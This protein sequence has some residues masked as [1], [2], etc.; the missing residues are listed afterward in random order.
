MRDERTISVGTSA[1]ERGQ[2]TQDFVVGIG[3]F[4]LAIAFVFS[5]LPSLITPFDSPAGGAETAQADRIADQVVANLS[6]GVQ[7]NEIIDDEF[8]ERY[9]EANETEL[10]KQIGLRAN[11]DEEIVYDN[12]NISIE[13]LN[14]QGEDGR[15]VNTDELAAGDTYDNQSA[16]SAARIV[17]VVDEDG[18][19][20]E[21]CE[22]ACR[23]V[24]RTW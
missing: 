23:L 18:T 17:T 4:I 1:W 8:E 6:D 15:Y 11:E 16:A 5:F 7:A 22:S 24:V 19:P 21:G 9:V 12:V 10:S 2:T 13:R 3:I 14:P 20:P